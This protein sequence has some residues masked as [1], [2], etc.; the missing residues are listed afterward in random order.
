[1]DRHAIWR[2]VRN[3]YAQLAEN[4]PQGYA[5]VVEVFLSAAQNPSGLAKC[6]HLAIQS[7]DGR[8]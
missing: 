4:A 7:S 2:I 3:N 6:R 1:M 8:Y 5:P